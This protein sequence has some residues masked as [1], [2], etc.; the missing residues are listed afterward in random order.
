MPTYQVSGQNGETYN[1]ESEKELSHEDVLKAVGMHGVK[2]EESK[3][4]VG[5]LRRREGQGEIAASKPRRERTFLETMS[6]ASP[7][8]LSPAGLALPVPTTEEDVKSNEKVGRMA[9]PYVA[10]ALAS[11]ALPAKY[12]IGAAKSLAGYIVRSALAGG[13]FTGAQNATEQALE[14]RSNPAELGRNIAGGAVANA[15]AGPII[16]KAANAVGGGIASA[17]AP[18]AAGSRIASGMRGAI[19]GLIKPLVEPVE[20]AGR[21]AAREAIQSA[22]GIEVPTTPGDAV[23]KYV[24]E[25]KKPISGSVSPQEMDGARQAVIYAATKIAPPG[26]SPSQIAT[27]TRDLLKSQ[28]APIDANANAAIDMFS[29]EIADHLEAS[30]VATS[31]RGASLIGPGTDRHSA[32]DAVKTLAGEGLERRDAAVT[33]AYDEFRDHPFVKVKGKATFTSQIAKELESQALKETVVNENKI[34][35][36]KGEAIST[37]S[38]APIPATLGAIQREVGQIKRFADTDQSL[39]DLLRYRTLVRDSVNDPARMVGIPERDKW[40]LVSALTKD[41]DR[42]VSSL[43]TTGLK[44]RLQAANK[45]Y[46]ETADSYKDPFVQSLSRDVGV[47]KGTQPSEVYSQLTGGNAQSNFDRLKQISGDDYPKVLESVRR[48]L[49]QEIHEDAFNSVSGK[50][51]L[52]QVVK[53]LD[54]FKSNA[55]KEF[56][57]MF[58]NYDNVVNL[59]KRQALIESSGKLSPADALKS[60]QANPS[61]IADLLEPVSRPEIARSAANA[62]SANALREK[63]LSNQIYADVMGGKTTS[64]ESDPHTLINKIIGG[65]FKVGPGMKPSGG[66]GGYSPDLVGQMMD[67]IHRQDPQLASRLQETY[68]E[69][70]I[71]DARKSTKLGGKVIDPDELLNLLTEKRRGEIASKILGPTKTKDLIEAAQLLKGTG[72]TAKESMLSMLGSDGINAEEVARAPQA[73][74]LAFLR[75]N[76]GIPRLKLEIAGKILNNNSLRKIAATPFSK[77]TEPQA[78]ELAKAVSEVP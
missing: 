19:G 39:E 54:E 40:K 45:L 63:A 67:S 21:R 35:G 47:A 52:G 2:T 50:Y 78:R 24:Q 76:L 12:A 11:E 44:N 60:L 58:P 5:E 46:A 61:E 8:N 13:T 55:P 29:K 34:V 57:S 6:A 56:G 32:G 74:R 38:V 62:I 7:Q 9:A 42:I 23:G 1:I 17:I 37:E 30:G 15:V 22:Y 73:G 4:G 14:G 36:P 3:P 31:A 72:P 70:L 16:G 75:V 25:L 59:A 77:L 71:N 43:P 64:A 18:E 65:D 51:N 53:R 49:A 33:K 66:S 27:A 68:L 69:S 41:I 20:S 48:G 10:G 26:A 28:L